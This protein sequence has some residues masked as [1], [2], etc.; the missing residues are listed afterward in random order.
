MYK[1]SYKRVTLDSQIINKI[2]I[3]KV[4]IYDEWYVNNQIASK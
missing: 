4:S 1:R 2:L 3:L